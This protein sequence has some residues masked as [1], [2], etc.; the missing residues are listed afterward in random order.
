MTDQLE[1]Q[2]T[3]LASHFPYPTYPLQRERPTLRLQPATFAMIAF[4]AVFIPVMLIQIGAVTLEIGGT[5]ELPDKLVELV[6]KTTWQDAQSAVGFPLM[7]PSSLPEPDAVY[8]QNSDTVI[9]VWV[10]ESI[11]KNMALYQ[12]GGEQ[13]TILKQ[14]DAVTTTTVNGRLAIWVDQPHPIQ[15]QRDGQKINEETY[16]VEGNVLIWLM[17]GITYRLETDHDLEDARA[18]AESLVE[19]GTDSD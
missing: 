10:E 8:L 11:R 3:Q 17:E 1:T 2:I 12:M 7:K 16:L 15:F 6:G 13:Y 14:A 19:M 5:P 4:V 18:I 9:F